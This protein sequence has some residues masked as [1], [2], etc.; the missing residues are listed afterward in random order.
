MNAFDTAINYVTFPATVHNA[1]HASCTPPPVLADGPG[2]LRLSV[3]NATWRGVSGEAGFE[4]EYFSLVDL[5]V[6]KRPFIN[7]DVGHLQPSARLSCGGTP[8]DFIRCF[9]RDEQGVVVTMTVSPTARHLFV[10]TNCLGQG[11]MVGHDLCQA[12]VH[13]NATLQAVGMTWSW[14]MIPGDR[15][16]PFNMSQLPPNVHNDLDVTVVFGQ[17]VIHRLVRFMRVTANTSDVKHAVQVDHWTKTL[18]A[19]G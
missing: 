2:L 18:S 4:V 13:V 17:Y 19:R 10:R 5:A 9:N 6:S 3:D 11:E 1:T 14:Q 15:A 7:T 8:C 12:A 16:L